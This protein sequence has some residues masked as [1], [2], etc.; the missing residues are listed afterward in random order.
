MIDFKVFF[1]GWQKNAIEIILRRALLPRNLL[2]IRKIGIRLFLIWYQILSVY[3]NTNEL[4]DL[5]F[6][7]CLPYFPLRDG[8]QSEKILQVLI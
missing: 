3:N 8:Q 6:Q 1:Q 7:C 4:L 5:V 2:T